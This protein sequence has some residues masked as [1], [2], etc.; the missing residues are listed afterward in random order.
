MLNFPKI[1]ARFE[2]TLPILSSWTNLLYGGLLRS[3]I[4]FLWLLISEKLPKKKKM[5]REKETKESQ[6]GKDGINMWQIIL[7][8]CTIKVL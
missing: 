6:K 2:M 8:I 3:Q 1:Y 7:F 4:L 5:K